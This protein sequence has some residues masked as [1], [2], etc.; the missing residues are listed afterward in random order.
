MFS[1]GLEDAIRHECGHLI[2]AKTLGFETGIIRVRTT[3]A[4]AELNLL[5]ALTSVYDAVVF[6]ER[7]VQVLYAGAVAQSL[8]ANG[9]VNGPHCIRYLETTA[10]DDFSKIREILR[11]LVGFKHPGVSYEDFAKHLD[12]ETGRLS[13]MA[14]ALVEK[15]VAVIK[16]LAQFVLTKYDQAGRP[17]NFE[18][19]KADID[20]SEPVRSLAL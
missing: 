15:H 2:A 7:R 18:L 11:L 9:K 6:I 14:G 13:E 4:G 1:V 3:S 19:A 16:L 20:T 17:P 5:P 8:D 12:E 10:S